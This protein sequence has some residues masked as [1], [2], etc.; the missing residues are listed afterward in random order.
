MPHG[1]GDAGESNPYAACATGQIGGG[2]IKSMMLSK[3][4]QS[5]VA[6][7]DKNPSHWPAFQA[8]WLVT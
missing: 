4:V 3:V 2:A 5:A 1:R 7:V 6:V 8:T